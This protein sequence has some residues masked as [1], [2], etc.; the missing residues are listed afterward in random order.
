MGTPWSIAKGSRIRDDH[1]MS[2]RKQGFH[3]PFADLELPEAPP[4]AATPN[5]PP[6]PPEPSNPAVGRESDAALFLQEMRGVAHLN[7]DARRVEP[8]KVL[9]AEQPDEDAL[10]LAELEGLVRGE[11]TFDLDDT[12]E[13]VSGRAPGVSSKTL[14]ALRRGRMAIR[15]HIDLH[16][17]SREGA[18]AELNRFIIEARRDDQRCVLVVTG[19]GRSSPGGISVLRETLP[20]WLSRAPLRAHV[21]AFCTAQRTDGGPGAFYILLRRAGIRPFGV[22]S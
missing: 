6:A 16:G 19:R 22:E 7:R 21:L 3:T 2:R 1:P 10:A 14:S 8:K 4:A 12:G 13:M 15:R 9:V 11:G 18:R 5:R 20:R 17:L